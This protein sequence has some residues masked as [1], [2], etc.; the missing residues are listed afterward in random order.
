SSTK[1]IGCNLQNITDCNAYNGKTQ[2]HFRE[3]RGHGHD[4]SVPYAYGVNV[5][6]YINEHH[7]E[8]YLSYKMYGNKHS[9]IFIFC[10]NIWQRTHR[11]A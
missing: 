3:F 5:E 1:T 7:R 9:A 11:K 4:K 10:A 6:K 2:H 8:A